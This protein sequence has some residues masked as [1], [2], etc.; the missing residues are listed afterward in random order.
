MKTLTN[1]LD[2]STSCGATLYQGRTVGIL[3]ILGSGNYCKLFL[4]T[5]A[6]VEK[7]W[8]VCC[9]ASPWPDRDATFYR[10]FKICLIGYWSGWHGLW[11][12]WQ[13]WHRG[14]RH[15]GGAAV[16]SHH[17]PMHAGSD[18]E[19]LF[20][21]SFWRWWCSHRGKEVLLWRATNVPAHLLERRCENFQRQVLLTCL[22]RAPCNPNTTRSL[23]VIMTRR[24]SFTGVTGWE[25]DAYFEVFECDSHCRTNSW[26]LQ[27]VV[28]VSV[29]VASHCGRAVTLTWSHLGMTP[30]S[31]N[32]FH[33]SFL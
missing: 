6:P 27:T 33:V 18:G 20:H 14:R 9:C 5:W 2:V 15:E 4:S 10:C 1:C 17:H 7:M 25:C 22:W 16:P 8:N 12:F 21:S 31:R 26:K 19:H 29:S 23:I 28:V 13:W 11:S 3:S 32:A 24:E 30:S